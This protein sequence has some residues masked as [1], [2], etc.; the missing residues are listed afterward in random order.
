[1]TFNREKREKTDKTNDSKIKLEKLLRLSEKKFSFSETTSAVVT[2]M[3]LICCCLLCCCLIQ[4]TYFVTLYSN[5]HFLPFPPF[6]RKLSLNYAHII[7]FFFFFEQIIKD[8][9]WMGSVKGGRQRDDKN[10]NRLESITQMW[11]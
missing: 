4:F 10:N 1:M 8:W 9:R 6:C 3:L 2:L 11:S 7:V 5:S